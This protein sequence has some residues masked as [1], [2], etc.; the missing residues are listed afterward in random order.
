[1][2]RGG[3]GGGGGAYYATI[4]TVCEIDCVRSICRTQGPHCADMK[5]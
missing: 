2:P 1:M 4:T 3:G 5:L